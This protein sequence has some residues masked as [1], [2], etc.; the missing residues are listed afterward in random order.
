[1]VA[2]R[3]EYHRS[4]YFK[5]HFG[6]GHRKLWTTPFEVPA[7]DLRAYGGGLAPVRQVGSLQSIGLA[8]KGADGKSYTFRALDKDPTRI[9]PAEWRDSF[10]AEIFQDQTTAS[11]PGVA[12]VVPALAEAAGVAHT[13]PRVVFMPDDEALGAFRATFG[14][15]P[16][17]IDEYPTAGF[18]GALEIISTDELWKR[19]RAGEGWVDTEALLQARLFDLFLGDWDRHVGQWR[20]MRLPGR[21]GLVALPEDRDQAFSDYSGV[22]LSLARSAVPKLLAWRDDYDNL[23]GLVLQ[24]REVDDWLLTGVERAAFQVTARR[25]QERLTDAVIEAAVRRMPPAWFAV[26]GERLVRDLR[27]RRDLLPQAADGFYERLARWVDVQGTDGD[28]LARLERQAD[29]GA[30]LELSRAEEAGADPRVYF[31]RRF[32]PGETRDVRI[33]LYAGDDRFVATGPP[34]GI[35]VHVSGGAG[36]DRLDDAQ[37]GGTS[38]H[39]V[40]EGE[41]A[42]GRGTSVSTREWTRVPHKK[43]TPW[44]DKRDYGSL[45]PLQ[46]LVWWEP[47]PGVVLSFGANH[48][49]YGFRKQ[50]YASLQHLAVEFKTGRTAFGANYRGDFR[51]ARPGFGTVV[52]LDADGAK[53]YNF[54]GIGNETPVVG[55]EFNEADQQAFEG[56]VSLLAWE[57][58]R[59][60]FAFVLGPDVRYARNRAED[61]T[62]LATTRPYGFG[63]FG[64]AGAGFKM[65]L[66]TRGRGLVGMG[67][68]QAGLVPESRRR[69]T[70]LEAEVEGRV[71]PAG[72]DVADTFGTLAGHLTGYWQP[73]SRL[74]LGGRVGGQQVWGTAPW[75]ESAFLGGSDT[76]RGY[77]RN[78]FAGDAAAW[79]NAQVMVDVFDLNLVLPLR[80]GLLGL[81]DTGRVWADAESSD[82]WHSSVGGGLYLRLLTSDLVVHGL[83]A[84]GDEGTRVY[85][86]IGFGL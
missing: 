46:P 16:G 58:P 13:E 73:A 65:E 57:N 12:F 78:R 41:V 27:A 25:L 34:G 42:R 23:D 62:L 52:L 24:G 47:D 66:K 51:W 17:T 26:S 6:E 70:G 59:R 30:L 31:R 50:P 43:E 55:D 28:D 4:G 80:V 60:T 81:A 67:A 38:F 19:W 44:M 21:E 63:D 35:E 72:W 7:L 77:D 32:L 37:S 56:F 2:G 83:L 40:A 11:H 15:K 74:T 18:Q 8:L 22:M 75:H 82:T 68:A 53:N 49:R 84:H 1:V 3:P 76:V 9:L 33:Y 10:P 85:V 86:N 69:Y 5:W 39:D 61:D 14:G 29:G 20:W 36:A 79:F 71:Y 54:Y 64:Q 45:T 48:Y